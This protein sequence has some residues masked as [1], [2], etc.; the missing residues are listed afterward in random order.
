M[1]ATFGSG[2]TTITGIADSL[3]QAPRRDRRHRLYR[4]K[5]QFAMANGTPPVP[6]RSG[7]IHRHRLNRGGNRQL[8]RI[9]H[10]SR[11][12]DL[13]MPGGSR[14]TTSANALEGK[15]TKEAPRPDIR[16]SE[17]PSSAA[18]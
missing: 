5:A 14:V 3:R 10:C 15:T 18:T 6:A 4:P 17:G 7:R 16:G 11:D 13:P 2:L 8:N 12:P 9:L 1:L